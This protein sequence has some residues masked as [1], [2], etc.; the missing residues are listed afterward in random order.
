M[1]HISWSC[2]S[3]C[4]LQKFPNLETLSHI[5]SK[6]KIGLCEITAANSK[7]SMKWNISSIPYMKNVQRKLCRFHQ[8][9]SN[10]PLMQNH[11]LCGVMGCN[12]VILICCQVWHLHI[13]RFRFY[14]FHILCNKC[15]PLLSQETSIELDESWACSAGELFMS[16]QIFYMWFFI[17]NKSDFLA[18]V[19]C[20]V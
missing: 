10:E 11:H 16:I 17:Y 18:R 8:A 3:A 20:I 13:Q 15:C 9:V 19:Y 4:C 1:T 6:V 5:S 2:S 12:A 14:L 7:W